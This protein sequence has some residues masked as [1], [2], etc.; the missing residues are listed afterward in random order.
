MKIEARIVG[1]LSDH[2]FE[3]RLQGLQLLLIVGFP[4]SFNGCSERIIRCRNRRRRSRSNGEQSGIRPREK[5]EIS[6]LRRTHRQVPAFS[7][8]WNTAKVSVLRRRFEDDL[9]FCC[10]RGRLAKK[11]R[12]ARSRAEVWHDVSSL[13]AS[14][15][16]P[17]PRKLHPSNFIFS[18]RFVLAL[19]QGKLI[20]LFRGSR[21]FQRPANGTIGGATTFCTFSIFPSA[22]ELLAETQ[23]AS[24]AGRALQSGHSA[25]C[26][27]SR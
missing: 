5:A 21:K 27:A 2:L 25:G 22:G 20:G 9:E 17:R 16:L 26:G 15:E 14:Q 8:A 11:D 1:V 13:D 7:Y 6:T 12:A 4:G 18:A 24:S 10:A 3:L 19:Q 23:S